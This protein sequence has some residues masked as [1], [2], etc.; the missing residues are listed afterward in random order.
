MVSLGEAQTTEQ[1]GG[2]PEPV[3]AKGLGMTPEEQ[4]LG[5]ERAEACFSTRLSR[6]F[7]ENPHAP[8]TT[9]LGPFARLTLLGIRRPRARMP[10]GR[11]GWAPS[12]GERY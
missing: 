10:A 9:G 4:K 5:E 1:I 12:L 7:K 3:T 11:L 6:L 8:R 2:F